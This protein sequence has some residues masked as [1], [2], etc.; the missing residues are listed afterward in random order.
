MKRLVCL[1]M[2]MVSLL[3]ICAMKQYEVCSPD[4]TLKIS[5]SIGETITYSVFKNS[6]QL[7]N[8]SQIS[9]QVEGGKH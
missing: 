9:M 8:P 6:Y 2:S 1:M 3:P 7:M 4:A 5:L